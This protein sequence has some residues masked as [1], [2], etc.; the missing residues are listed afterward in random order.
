MVEEKDIKKRKTIHLEIKN[1]FREYTLSLPTKDASKFEGKFMLNVS[2]E[3][4]DYYYDKKTGY[5]RENNDSFMV[6]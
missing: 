5:R 6:F 1:K 2:R 4:C 3:S